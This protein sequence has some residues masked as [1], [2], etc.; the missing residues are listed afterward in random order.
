[1][2]AR[3]RSVRPGARV[4]RIGFAT[5]ALAADGAAWARAA[6]LRAGSDRE[7]PARSST[8]SWFADAAGKEIGDLRFD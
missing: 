3:T 4:S 8:C 7:P 2:V 5:T 6:G 1:M